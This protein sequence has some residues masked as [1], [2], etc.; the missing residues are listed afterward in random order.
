MKRSP[1]PPMLG[2]MASR[3]FHHGP[4]SPSISA[5][6]VGLLLLL[7]RGSQ[8][9]EHLRTGCDLMNLFFVI[10][11]YTDVEP[12]PVVR[13]IVIDALNI[14]NKPRPKEEIILGRIA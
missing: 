6:L 1:L 14:P 3:R 8:K 13:D 11:E 12:A 4:E 9:P 5:I 7:I 2:F 10:D